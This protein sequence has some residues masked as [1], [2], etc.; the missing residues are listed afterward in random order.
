MWEGD[1]STI[2]KDMN[3][4]S[5]YAK[6]YDDFV[7]G[8]IDDIQST[9]TTED[10]V[11][12]NEPEDLNKISY[13]VLTLDCVI[14]EAHS[15][16]NEITSYPISSGFNVSDH[17]IKRNPIFKMQGWI[18]NVNMPTT[19]VSI[20]NIGKVAGAMVSRSMGP[21]IG[22]LLGSAAN[23]VDNLLVSGNPIKEAFEQLKIL[24]Q[25]GT[26]VHVSTL[27]GTY[28][29][30]VIRSMEI[31]QN[32]ITASVL[33]VTLTFEKLFVIDDSTGNFLLEGQNAAI[34]KGL[35]QMTPTQLESAIG[36]IQAQGINILGEWVL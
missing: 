19:Q 30:C 4:L 2:S 6:Q 29:N 18:T 34:K 32:V 11:T 23:V 14:Q 17:T 28:E 27:I 15:I 9:L 25:N 12:E 10:E 21:V 13:K 24:V 35:N 20:T 16:T 26:L 5:K 7:D 22:S 1:Q 31:Q 33:P 3:P 8:A 36:M